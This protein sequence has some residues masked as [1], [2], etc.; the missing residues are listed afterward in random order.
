[1]Y[2]GPGYNVVRSQ[3]VS[4][5]WNSELSKLSTPLLVALCS[6]DLT[7]GDYDLLRQFPHPFGGWTYEIRNCGTQTLENC[8]W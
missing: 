6:V 4:N 1:M 8:L 2:L 5:V 7:N 3:T